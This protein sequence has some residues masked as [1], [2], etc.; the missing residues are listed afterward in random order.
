M[1]W[2]DIIRG[3]RE[4][5]RSVVASAVDGIIANGVLNFACLRGPILTRPR[6]ASDRARRGCPD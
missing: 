2:A 4:H 1:Y 3:F 6:V 5:G